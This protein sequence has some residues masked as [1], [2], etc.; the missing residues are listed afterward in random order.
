ML[1]LSNAFSH[2]ELRAFDA[3]VRK[4]LGLPA[5]PEPA[6]GADLRRG[7]QDRRPRRVAALRARPAHARGDPRR[8][9]DR[10]GRDP[11]P[12]H[13][14][15][16]P[17]P[18]HR[19][20]RRSRRAARCSCPRPSSRGST[21]SARSWASPCTRTRATAAPA[22]SARRTPQVTA[23]RQLSTWL[24]QLVEDERRRRQPVR[25]PS[26]ASRPSG[27]PVNPEREAGPRHRGGDRVHRALARRPPPPAVR[28]RRR[29][30]QGRPVRPAGAARDG[31]P[32]AAL[33]DRVQVPAGAGRDRCSRTSSRTSGARGPSRP[34]P[35]CGRSRWRARP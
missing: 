6:D 22:A 16:D 15:R 17:G 13:D 8:R 9:L 26:R 23:G 7:A 14:P 11:Q 4:G 33:G 27:F 12:A 18:P 21:R 31:Q 10:R 19:S 2:D 25:R 30:G 32:G 28:D 35:T 29:R 5:A 1:S 24:Y 34:S 3:R 20:P